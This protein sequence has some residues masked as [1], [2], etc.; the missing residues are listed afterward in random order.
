M[1]LLDRLMQR[2]GYGRVGAHRRNFQ[3]ANVNRLTADW[4]TDTQTIDTLLRDQLTI[5]RSRSRDLAL[6][7]AYASKFLT[8][9]KANTLGDQGMTL[10]NKSADVRPN[11]MLALDESANRQIEEA[12]W[13]WGR[14][15]NCTVTKN[16]TWLEAQHLILQSIGTDGEMF[17]KLHAPFDNEFGF[18]IELVE[19]DL[20]DE[21]KNETLANGNRVRLGVEIN[22]WQQSIAYWLHKTNPN[23]YGFAMGDT[24]RVRLAA[25]NVLHPF[26]RFRLGQTRGYPWLAVTMEPLKML[27]GYEEAEVVAARIGASKMG[28]FKRTGEVT[29]KGEDGGQGSVL[30][31]AQPGGFEQLPE[32]LELQAWDPNH[33]N[34]GFG[35]FVKACLRRIAAGLN[36]SYNTLANDLEGVN[37]SSGRLGLQDEREFWKLMQCWFSD[38]VCNPIF[39]RWLEV[40]TSN[41]S[42]NLPPSK[43]EKFKAANWHGRRW[44]WVDPTKEVTAKIMELNAGLT[45][46]TRILAELGIDE[47]EL[48]DEIAAFKQK[49]NDKDLVLPEISVSIGQQPNSSLTNEE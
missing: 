15:K 2:F 26:M 9:L 44:Q 14:S 22:Q 1:K 8:M 33:P 45:S 31:D 48:L 32:G 18:A 19:A 13:Q 24:S 11:G 35:A 12:W 10:K 39:E 37:F 42:V 16:M 27:G 40:A 4:V 3:G 20:C 36:V 38:H 5:L 49:L 21:R 25:D 46:H 34:S 29:Y 23:D 28:F 30:M 17:I 7:N 47:D 41:R 43:L 6:N